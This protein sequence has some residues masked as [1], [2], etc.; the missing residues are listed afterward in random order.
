VSSKTTRAENGIEAATN[1]D[2]QRACEPGRFTQGV[3]ESIDVE[4]VG[5]NFYEVHSAS[6]STYDVDLRTGSCTCPD[7]ARR[8]NRFGPCKHAVRAAIADVFATGTVASETGAFVASFAR[9][10]GCP[11]DGHGGDCPGPL[12]GNGTLP[13]PTCCDAARSP[14]VDEYD[15][16][17]LVVRDESEGSA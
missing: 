11:A 8:G 3:T 10:H 6:G 9:E 4:R 14:G 1:D 2:S 7:H 16:W 17:K 13:C 5:A 12:G 15:V